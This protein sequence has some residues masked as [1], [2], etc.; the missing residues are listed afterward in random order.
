VLI[1]GAMTCRWSKSM[2]PAPP[3]KRH[4]HATQARHSSIK[5]AGQ[6]AAPFH[7]LDGEVRHDAFAVIRETIRT[8]DKVAT[9]RVVLTNRE[10]IIALEAR[11]KGLVGKMLL[12][13]L[14][15]SFDV[16][17]SWPRDQLISS[18]LSQSLARETWRID[19]GNAGSIGP[20]VARTLKAR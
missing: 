10:H 18:L 15:A 2:R 14:P 11:G 13:Y 7:R 6:S 9:A 20:C 12:R 5:P 4:S 17:P 19:S 8:R 1:S 3:L 16:P